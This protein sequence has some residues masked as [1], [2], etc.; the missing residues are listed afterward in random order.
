M[1]QLTA[2]ILAEVGDG[3][4]PVLDVGA[5]TGL[6]VQ[7]LPIR[8][9]L[10]I[11]ALDISPQMLGVA[12]GKGLYRRAIEADLTATLPIA[13]GV[14]GAI[15]SSGTFTHGHVG[16]DA[17]DELL[18]VAHR[19][20]VFVLAINKAHFEARGFGDKFAELEPLI[21]GL[22]LRVVQ[23][24]GPEATGDHKDDQAYIAVFSKR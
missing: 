11:D 2:L 13:D 19:R 1:P 10:E 4:S 8:A 20:A 12:M 24:Y 18:R 14:Y 21:E 3:R 7:A 5:G 23:I 9:G 16:P 15:V 17:I 6:L 22:V